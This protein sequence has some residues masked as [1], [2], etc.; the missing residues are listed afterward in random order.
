MLKSDVKSVLNLALPGIDP[1]VTPTKNG[2]SSDVGSAVTIG[3][4]VVALGVGY[5]STR[6]LGEDNPIEEVAEEVIE[7]QTGADIDLTPDSEE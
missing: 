3:I 5:L 2:T 6:W 1:T 4:L 7:A